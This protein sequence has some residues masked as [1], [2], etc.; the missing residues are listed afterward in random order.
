MCPYN[1]T[2]LLSGILP[3]SGYSIECIGDTKYSNCAYRIHSKD[4]MVD[5]VGKL[6]ESRD[7]V[8]ILLESTPDAGDSEEHF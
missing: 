8:N 2:T 3:L 4:D 6:C 1:N 5:V 7:K